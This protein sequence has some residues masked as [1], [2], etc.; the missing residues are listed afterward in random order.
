MS[1]EQGD[2]AVH[3]ASAD[4]AALAE[5]RAVSRPAI[6]ALVLGLA[7]ATAL[8]HPLLLAVPVVA[9]AVGLA[10]MASVARNS[11]TLIGRKAAL[12]GILL[13]LL[14]ASWAPARIVGR[15]WLLYDHARRFSDA[16]VKLLHEQEY[17]KAHQLTVEA[18]RRQPP[19][20]DLKAFYRHH[21]DEFNTLYSH[22]SM[23]I[24]KRLGSKIRLRYAGN[25]RQDRAATYTNVVLAYAAGYNEDGRE[26]A[27]RVHVVVQRDDDPRRGPPTW[28]VRGVADPRQVE[29]RQRKR[30][31]QSPLPPTAEP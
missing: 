9:V 12:T 25:V 21:P 23:S 8:A 30:E 2:T 24:V 15:R 16:W 18:A 19:E 3:F 1:G 22:P 26:K 27:L 17:E 28:H 31:E 4:E 14:F 10:A 6:V 5:Y 13:A 11:Q 20:A 7:S 29:A